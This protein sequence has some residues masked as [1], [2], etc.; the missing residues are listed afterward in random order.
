MNA[1]QQT[2]TGALAESGTDMA[3]LPDYLQ[4][5][6]YLTEEDLPGKEKRFAD[7]L[8][9]SS[10]ESVSQLMSHIKS[11]IDHIKERIAGLNRI[12]H[13]VDFDKDKYLQLNTTA[14]AHPGIKEFEQAYKKVNTFSLDVKNPNPEGH[15]AALR[16]LITLLHI[17]VEKPER[18]ASKALLD[19]RHRLAFSIAIVARH[20]EQAPEIRT[21]L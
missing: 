13:S 18:L 19:A 9:Q 5:L 11:R 7:Y 1:A 2:D 17:A 4:R 12:L 8:T 14:V 21:G 6:Q 20:G 10:T 3:D 15:Y 16:E